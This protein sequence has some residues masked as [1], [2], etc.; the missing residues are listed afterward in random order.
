M[1]DYNLSLFRLALLE[2][3][4]G[5]IENA[6]TILEKLENDETIK[7]L[8]INQLLSNIDDVQVII[9]EHI[10]SLN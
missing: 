7:H 9:E 1:Q 5:N 10:E 6:K 8:F 2:R 3:H 4:K